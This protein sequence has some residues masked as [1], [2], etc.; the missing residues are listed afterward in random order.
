MIGSVLVALVIAFAAGAALILAATLSPRSRTAAAE[1]WPLYGSEFVIVGALL[2]PAALGGLVF[3]AALVAF[4]LRGEFEMFRLA[5][6]PAFGVPQTVVAMAGVAM[7][8]AAAAGEPRALGIATG[9]GAVLAL[10]SA[11]A[12]RRG[13]AG[14]RMALAAEASIVFPMVCAAAIVALGARAEGFLWLVTAYGTVEIND[15][16]AL[17]VGKLFGRTP[18]LPRLSPRKTVEGLVGGFAAGIA[19]GLLLAHY[20]LGLSPG[21]SAGPVAVILAAGFAGD[22]A[23]SALKRRLGKKDFSAVLARH[24]GV[25]DIYDSMLF[26]APALLLYLAAA[27][28]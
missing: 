2:I 12:T 15:G 27:K 20:L 21:A 18:A 28:S 4:A 8:A 17:L 3:A 13:L 23:T 5:D 7:I 26:A 1:L 16:F 22:L 19:A 11:V 10:L 14:L 24:G 9:A 6:L 25:L